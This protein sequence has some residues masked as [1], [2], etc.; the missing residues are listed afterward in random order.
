MESVRFL[1][2]LLMKYKSQV[3][4]LSSKFVSDYPLITFPELIYSEMMQHLSQIVEG[5]LVF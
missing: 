3:Y 5:E 1:K 2:E 4:T